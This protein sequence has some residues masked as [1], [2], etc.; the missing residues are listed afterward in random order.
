[1]IIFIDIVKFIL[2]ILSTFFSCQIIANGNKR[3][4]YIGTILICFSMA[5]FEYINSGLL[6]AIFFGELIFISIDRLLEKSKFKYLFVSL[7]PIRN[8]RLFINFKY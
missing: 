8:F 2:L 3:I 6:E 4:S 5:I 7:I 1:M